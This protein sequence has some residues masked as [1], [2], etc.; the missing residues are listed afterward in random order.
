MASRMRPPAGANISL[1]NAKAETTAEAAATPTP[2]LDAYWGS[3]GAT[4]P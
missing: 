1:Q 2:K 3:T 4:R